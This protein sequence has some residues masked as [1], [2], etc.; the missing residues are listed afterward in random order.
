MLSGTP[1]KPPQL[2]ESIVSDDAGVRKL[3]LQ[4]IGWTESDLMCPFR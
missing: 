2:G 3:E 4:A 1:F